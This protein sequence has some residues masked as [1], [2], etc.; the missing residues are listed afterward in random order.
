LG[1]KEADFPL[2]A[3]KALEDRSIANNPVQPSADDIIAVLK[4]V[5]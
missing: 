3:R 5:F 4:K 2:L 1:V